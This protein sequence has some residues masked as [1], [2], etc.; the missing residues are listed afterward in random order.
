[1]YAEAFENAAGAS[2]KKFNLLKKNPLGYI[3]LSML[4]GMYIGFGI[5]LAFTI[6]SQLG[7]NP[8]SNLIKGAIFGVALSLVIIPGAEL[9]TGNN[10]VMGAGLFKNKVSIGQSL[11]LWAVCWIGNFLGAILLAWIFTASGLDVPAV[12]TTFTK[13]AAAKMS[14][15]ALQLVLRGILCNIL[16][17]LAVWSGFQSKDDT[18]KLIM[19]WWCLLAFFSTGFEHSVANMTTLVVA[20]MNPIKAV[21]VVSIS[22]LF[23]NLL[24]VTLGNMIGGIF[25]VAFP[26]WMGSHVKKSQEKEA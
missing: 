16:V 18:A 10:F 21:G 6:G 14:A 12:A 17:C 7:N 19:V 24:W 2:A 13:A 20:L 8:F 5:L 23:Y 4:A 9:F 3:L 11:S 25:F 26:Y 15:P 1:M 22:G